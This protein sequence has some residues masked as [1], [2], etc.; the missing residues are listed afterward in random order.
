M[1]R[2]YDKKVLK[3]RGAN[4][5]QKKKNVKEKEKRNRNE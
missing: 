1:K 3:K 4:T 2:K 5:K